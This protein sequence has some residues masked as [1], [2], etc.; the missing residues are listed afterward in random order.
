MVVTPKKRDGNG[1][2]IDWARY[3]NR[4][5]IG[6]LMRWA[7][8]G[9]TRLPGLVQLPPEP[10]GRRGD[11]SLPGNMARISREVHLVAVAEAMGTLEGRD[12]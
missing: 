3:D 8:R 7:G 2:S 6:A 1:Y 5:A 11:L 4:R 10:H 9:R 12:D